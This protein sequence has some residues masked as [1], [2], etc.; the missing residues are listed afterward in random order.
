MQGFPKFRLSFPREEWTLP[1]V[2]RAR[3]RQHPERPFL[4]WAGEG[5]FRSY[6]ETDRMA[7]RLANG[8]ARLGVA[9]GDRVVLFLPNSLELLF[10]W[11]GLNKLGA[12]EAPINDSYKGSFLE[13]QFNISGARV[14]VADEALL[15][16][17]AESEAN[18]PALEHVVVWSRDG[19]YAGAPY[20]LG[21]AKVSTYAELA[22]ADDADPMA[23]LRPRDLGAI[24]FT[25]GTTG[26][27]KGV[28]MTHAHLYHFAEC[29]VQLVGLE[30][31]DVYMT[32]FPLFHGNAQFLT[33]YPSLIVGA[34]AVVYERFSAGDWVERIHR[35][36]AT[37]TNFL[38][39]TSSFVHAQPPGPRD[40]GHRLK[41]VFAV[42]VPHQIEDDFCRRFGIEAMLDGFGQTEISMTFMQPRG[43]AKPKGSCGVLLDEWF[44]VRLVDPATG[45]DVPE[46]QVGE[47]LVRH[48]VDDILLAGY[49]GM[50]EK[51]LEAFRNLWFHT[52]DGLRRD[53]DGWYFFTDRMK[54][55][56]RRR[57]ENISSYEVEAPIAAHPAVAAAAVIAVPAGFAAGEDEVKACVVL[58][59]GASLGH[60]ELADWCDRR[61]PYALVP[62]YFEFVDVLPVTE[63]GKVQ[64][65]K[66]RA[67]G[68]TPATWDRVA[69]GH[70]LEEDRRRQARRKEPAG[71]GAAGG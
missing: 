61:L 57:G 34:R 30:A 36:Q 17:V 23:P 10:L 32:A 65:E 20:R 48:K 37:V 15:D 47:L 64:K 31:D 35:T 71:G 56:L 11:F 16:R 22:D 8:F 29:V 46:G 19:R 62:R 55:A 21:R 66:L 2:L 49:V 18:M 24:L 63:N 26:P 27:S 13:H 69:A 60:G 38:G 42:P 4:Q 9:R 33:V 41:R 68:L 51:T 43:A 45:E 59:P 53:A 40:R 14:L 39:A 58:Q 12:V 3:A 67:A 6:G 54:D 50:P 70:L 7:S 52:G 25:S 44:D 28:M 1:Q 5:P